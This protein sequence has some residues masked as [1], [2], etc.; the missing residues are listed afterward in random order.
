MSRRRLATAALATTGCVVALFGCGSAAQSGSAGKPGNSGSF[1]EFAKCMRSHGVPSFPD[2]RPGGGIKITPG[3]GIDP[4]SPAFGRAR[5]DCRRRLP[6]GGPPRDVPESV[7]IAAVKHAQ[8][9]RAHGVSNYPDP[10]FPPGG[11]VEN[12]VPSSV[13]ANSPALQSAAKACGGE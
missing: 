1:L 10:T 11:G 5:Q 9:M 13:D 2:P 7:K 4:Q 8:C 12:I 6:G 3:S